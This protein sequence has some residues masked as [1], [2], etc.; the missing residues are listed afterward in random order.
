MA[1]ALQ[2]KIQEYAWEESVTE[3]SA[4]Y[5]AGGWFM[6]RLTERGIQDLADF[7]MIRYRENQHALL[8]TYRYLQLGRDSGQHRK[9]DRNI[10]SGTIGNIMQVSWTA[11]EICEFE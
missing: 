11:L 2:H 9:R 4:S 6:S 1:L 5:V 10:L 8:C 7:K 3:Q